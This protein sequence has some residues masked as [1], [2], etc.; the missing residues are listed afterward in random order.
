MVQK[1]RDLEKAGIARLLEAVTIQG[2]EV[3]GE[4]RIDK[5]LFEDFPVAALGAWPQRRRQLPP[6]IRHHD[7]VVKEGVVDV[8]EKHDV[9]RNGHAIRILY[10]RALREDAD[11]SGRPFPLRSGRGRSVRGVFVSRRLLL[12]R[13]HRDGGH[14]RSGSLVVHF[15]GRA[16]TDVDRTLRAGV[17]QKRHLL[18]LL[19]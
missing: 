3:I 4:S 19:A 16:D 12:D 5:K 15:H 2:A 6:E 9:R 18:R 13:L 11:R 17:E 10:L 7:A 1:Q 8:E 14:R